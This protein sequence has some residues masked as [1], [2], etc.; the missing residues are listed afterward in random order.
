MQNALI[1]VLCVPLSKMQLFLRTS[2][3]TA[4]EE[5]LW[6]TPFYS[7]HPQN[8]TAKSPT[9]NFSV[10]CLVTFVSRQTFIQTVSKFWQTNFCIRTLLVLTIGRF[11]EIKQQCSTSEF[12]VWGRFKF[13]NKTW[14]LPTFQLFVYCS[15]GCKQFCIVVRTNYWVSPETLIATLA[16][17]IS[18]FCFF[19]Q[20][21]IYGNWKKAKLKICFLWCHICPYKDC[22][23]VL[24]KVTEVVS[25]WVLHIRV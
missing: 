14:F 4:R 19:I 25:Q 18:W 9:T 16:L 23:Y 2:Q 22:Q 24:G 20:Y 17:V 21:A 5:A 12:L 11:F 8:P 3:L 15:L 13:C 7:I 10:Q 6:S 1:T